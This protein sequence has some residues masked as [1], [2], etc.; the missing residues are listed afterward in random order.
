MKQNKKQKTKNMK[1]IIQNY[2]GMQP[3]DK[4]CTNWSE[5]QEKM[6]KEINEFLQEDILLKN[7]S[8]LASA[9]NAYWNQAY[10]ELQ[11][12]DLGDIEKELFKYQLSKSKEILNSLN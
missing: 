3:K 11:R 12:K 2:L 5:M 10:S 1:E 7:K 4:N 6:L 8:F 9:L